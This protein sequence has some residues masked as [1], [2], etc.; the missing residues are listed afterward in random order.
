MARFL[1]VGNLLVENI[2]MPDGRELRDR[3][4]GDA[5]YAA[6]GARAF[7][8]DAV[9]VVRLGRGFPEE[10]LS[11]L[12]TAGYEAGLLR[13][14]HPSVRLRVDW[15]VE[16][17]TRFT[18]EPGS[19]T[20]LDATPLPVELPPALLDGLEAVHIAPIPFG[21]MTEWLDWARRHARLVTL[22][23]HYQHL[24][25]DWDSVL[26]HVDAFLPS[27]AEATELLGGWPGPEEAVRALAAL[28]AR[29]VCIKLGAEGAI[30]FRGGEIVL[31]PARAGG[32]VDPT[33]C[34]DAFC[35]GFLVGL[36]E[37]G[38]LRSALAHGAAAAVFA[39]RDHGAAHALTVERSE[40]RR[41]LASLGGDDVEM[42]RERPEV[43]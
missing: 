30:G 40:A 29:T 11:A 27:R 4:G 23:P 10:L 17:G 43:V 32:A 38:E 1:T 16:G 22:D 26:P 19:G 25:A 9:P 18:F 41:L 13:S 37:T 12:R 6:L 15:G 28:G 3:L 36:H 14:P 31:I 21:P 5:I 20:Y 8:D 7:A 33:G 24:D 39:G 42:D 34:G 2:V 35:G